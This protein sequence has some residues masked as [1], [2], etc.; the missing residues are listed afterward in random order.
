MAEGLSEYYKICDV[1]KNNLFGKIVSQKRQNICAMISQCVLKFL[2][3][4]MQS[5]DIMS[6]GSKDR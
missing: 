6:H 2:Q 4:N 1:S 5:R 3:L